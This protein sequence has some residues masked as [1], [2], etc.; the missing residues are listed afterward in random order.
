M[1]FS[2]LEEPAESG[3][4]GL[5]KVKGALG[6]V[7]NAALSAGKSALK[8]AGQVMGNVEKAIIE[9]SDFSKREVKEKDAAKNGAVGGLSNFGS[10]DQELVKEFAEKNAAVLGSMGGNDSLDDAKPSFDINKD[11]HR[12]KFTVQFNP[13]ELKF[14]GYGGEEMAVQNYTNDPKKRGNQISSVSAH[15]EM[16][17]P[18]IFDR[19]NNQDAFYSDKFS[20]GQTNVAR[21]VGKLAV[22]AVTGNSYT[23]QP[24]VEA[25]TAIIRSGGKRL[26]HFSWGDM[27]YEGILNGVS[28]EYTMFNV[29]GEPIRANVNLRL[30][31]LDGGN[32]K[33][34]TRI[35]TSKYKKHLG[36]SKEGNV[37]AEL[38][39]LD[40]DG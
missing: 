3:L 22:N 6:S 14:T 9:I 39:S 13:N 17:I 30:V 21:G 16:N 34:T 2:T 29:N 40:L 25:F 18:L 7:G 8:S 36:F 32:Y 38:G 37:L 11:F 26:I 12:V 15:I 31:L 20:L 28:A 4:S 5:G 24:E 23:V 35:W 1:P 19:V 10:F 27:S 33:Q